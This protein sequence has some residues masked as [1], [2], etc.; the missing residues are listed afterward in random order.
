[1]KKLNEIG[2]RDPYILLHEN[3]YYMY[4]TRNTTAWGDADGFDVYVSEDLHNWEGPIEIF[5]NGGT[6][7]ATQNYWAPECI[8]YNNKFYLLA[9]FG[10][11]DCKKGVQILVSNSPTG[12]FVPIT[13]KP[14]TPQ[15]WNALDG[16]FYMDEQE[17]PWLLFSHSLP[18]ETKG[19]VCAMKLSKD[20]KEGIE[21][22]IVLFYADQAA[23]AK[24]I[25][26]AKEEF[27]L[28]G[29]VYL[30]DG[31]YVFKD[32]SG[33]LA[34]IW[35]GWGNHGYSVGIADSQNNRIEGPWIQR[36]KAIYDQNGGHGMIFKT[37]EGKLK[38]AL[39]SPNDSLKERA[40]F[41]DFECLAKGGR[42]YDRQTCR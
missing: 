20:L 13:E 24:P 8:F 1:M 39:H 37:K 7:W 15:T 12:A 2:I 31:P 25:P 33:K 10:S 26:F 4:G 5:H 35:S 16:T 23:W 17:T 34:M 18:E 40:V 41:L 38:L 28:D 9:T 6:F 29:K 11:P 14:I 32:E 22:P 19:A 36:E 42:Y 3:K 27:G 30:S 21:E